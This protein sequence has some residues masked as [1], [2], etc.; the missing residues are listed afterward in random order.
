MGRAWGWGR[1]LPGFNPLKVAGTRMN[2]PSQSTNLA[3]SLMLLRKSLL[4]ASGT[5][6]KSQ[7][8]VF[9]LS[10][11]GALGSA[12]SGGGLCERK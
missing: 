2:V 1:T 9:H 8:F 12:T 6:F 10:A 5:Y 3:A 4:T 7:T 11:L